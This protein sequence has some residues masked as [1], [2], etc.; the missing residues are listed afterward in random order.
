M[1]TY[2]GNL[3]NHGATFVNIFGWGAG[4]RDNPFRKF[5]ESEKAIEAYQKFL[6]G[7]TLQ[8]AH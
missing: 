7:E 3:F 8:E 1:E 5:A 6:E 4:P 2:L